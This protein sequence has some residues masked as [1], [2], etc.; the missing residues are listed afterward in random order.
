MYLQ[1]KIYFILKLM[2]IEYLFET[3]LFLFNEVKVYNVCFQ[4][5]EGAVPWDSCS[6]YKSV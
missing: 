5:Y 6:L 2:C 3:R 4:Q 1:G